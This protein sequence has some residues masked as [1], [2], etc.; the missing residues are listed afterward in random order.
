LAITLKD[1]VPPQKSEWHY[2]AYVDLSSCMLKRTRNNRPHPHIRFAHAPPWPPR[3]R[4]CDHRSVQGPEKQDTDRN[5]L[6]SPKSASHHLPCSPHPTTAEFSIWFAVV[7]SARIRHWEL[8]S[9]PKSEHPR[10]SE[11]AW[12]SPSRPG[13]PSYFGKNTLMPLQ[14]TFRKRDLPAIAKAPSFP[15]KRNGCLFFLRGHGSAFRP[16]IWRNYCW[17]V[18]CQREEKS[19]G[20][21]GIATSYAGEC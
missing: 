9:F 17:P 15:G 8:W 19:S 20:R 11:R 10:N 21:I 4:F 18:P 12:N 2:A 1:S 13:G 5:T 16:L 6:D 7:S 3:L 14:S